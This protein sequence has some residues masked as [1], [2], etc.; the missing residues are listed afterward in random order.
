MG[1]YYQS[2][3][4]ISVTVQSRMD[5]SVAG[6]GTISSGDRSTGHPCPF[7]CNAMVRNCITC[8]GNRVSPCRHNMPMKILPALTLLDFVA[9]DILE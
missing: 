9:I 5:T 6:Y 2:E 4:Y 8:A 3:S 1:I 7:D